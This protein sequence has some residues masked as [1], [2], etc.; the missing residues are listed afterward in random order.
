M[1]RPIAVC[2]FVAMIGCADIL[3]AH[4]QQP[5]ANLTPALIDEAIQLADED[6]A[7]ARFL[8]SYI[9]QARSGIGTGP[10]IGYFSTPFSRVVMAAVM[11]RKDGS[12][13]AAS[14]VPA[15]LLVPELQ[16]LVLSQ[17]AAYSDSPVAVQAVTIARRPQDGAAMRPVGTVPATS[18]HY[19]LFG[20][21]PKGNGALVAAM[22]MADV[23]AE[24][25]VRVTFSQVVRGSSAL[26]NC[27]DCAVPLSLTRL[28]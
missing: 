1:N 13:L 26:T 24:N 21:V 23:A 18:Q 28:R 27:K 3:P 2:V 25:T 12:K 15:N 9:L 10:L 20:I 4:A 14:E 22:P 16:M 17:S 5:V 19:A 7:T 11:A 6:K 8:Q